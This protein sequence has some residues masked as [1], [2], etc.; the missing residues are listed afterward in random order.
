MN[1]AIIFAG[2]TGKRMNTR[3]MPKQFLEMHAKPILVW[4][5]EKFQNHNEIDGII[6]VSN[7]DWMDYS[8]NLIK[9]FYLTK[10]KA[11]IPGGKTGQESIFNGITRA[12]ELYGDDATVL[13]H[14]GVRP[15]IDYETISKAI[16]CVESN[17]TAIT[18][19]PAVETITVI[20]KDGEVGEIIDR[21]K[22]Q[23]AKAP[24]CFR[25]GE[26][27]KAH[28]K[29]R[30]EGLHDFIDSASLMKHYGHRLFTVQGHSDNI[31]ITAPEDF[32]IFR[33]IV[34]AHENSQI[35]GL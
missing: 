31:K 8:E 21:S 17:G 16:A 15:L 3:T 1:I 32:Y 2:G 11:I 9:K 29:A 4:T 5:I 28:L 6:L 10:V 33:A 19:A 26:I 22:C 35:F 14:D 27:Y 12:H 24:Q 7:P 23:M 34:D 20:G 30:E 13:I 25:L 18:V